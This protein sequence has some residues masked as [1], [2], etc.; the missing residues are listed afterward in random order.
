MSTIDFSRLLSEFIYLEYFIVEDIE[1][2]YFLM[3]SLLVL[4]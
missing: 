3:N 2:L 1:S 4:D